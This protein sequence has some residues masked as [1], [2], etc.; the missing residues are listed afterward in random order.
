[1]LSQD[2]SFAIGSGPE[3][4][5]AQRPRCRRVGAGLPPEPWEARLKAK[6]PRKGSIDGRYGLPIVP[7]EIGRGL[8][9]SVDGDVK[10]GVA[11]YDMDEGWADIP[12]RTDQGH[13]IQRSDGRPPDPC[14]RIWGK[15]QVL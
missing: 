1:M 10:R 9:V 5:V 13:F 2:T 14:V 8:Q 6:A 4:L 11:A 12:M 7:A 15:V 3:T